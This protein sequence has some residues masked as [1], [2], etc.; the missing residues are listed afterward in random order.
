MLGL[1]IL[2]AFVVSIGALGYTFFRALLDERAVRN[3]AYELESACKRVIGAGQGNVE[4]V[5]VHLP[6]DYHMHFI[7]NQIVVDNFRVPERGFE[8]RFAENAPTLTPGTH[9][10]L[11][12]VS[13]GKLV[14]TRIS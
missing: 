14:V 12:T 2:G 4:N 5:E 6:G 3:A 10:L 7:D 9:L 1:V 8:L 13:D 11:V